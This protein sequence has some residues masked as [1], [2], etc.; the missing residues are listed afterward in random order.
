MNEKKKLYVKL[1]IYCQRVTFKYEM[2]NATDKMIHVS[3][4]NENMLRHF[5]S[6][7]SVHNDEGTHFFF[8]AV[9]A[10]SVWAKKYTQITITIKNVCLFA[11]QAM[12]SFYYGNRIL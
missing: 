3:T 10:V 8:P 4:V 6:R 12:I 11:L 2:H 9:G 5:H 7:S 1:K